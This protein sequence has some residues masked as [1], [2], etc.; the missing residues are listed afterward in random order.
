MHDVDRYIRSRKIF[1]WVGMSIGVALA[2]M[3]MWGT[4]IAGALLGSTYAYTQESVAPDPS[5]TGPGFESALYIAVSSWIAMPVGIVLFVLCILGFH[6][7]RKLER[8]QE[9][10]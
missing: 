6:R 1:V 3:P 8:L 4:V 9:L 7:L 5:I 2:M 10:E